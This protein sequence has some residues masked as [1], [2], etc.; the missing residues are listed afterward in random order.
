MSKIQVLAWRCDRD[1]CGHVWLAKEK[2]KACAKCK[3][4]NWDKEVGVKEREGSENEKT[5]K[6]KISKSQ[7]LNVGG[8]ASLDGSA[9]SP[10][11][12]RPEHPVNCPCMMCRP[13]K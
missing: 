6:N 9:V 4:R 1:G 2:P 13:K 10:I 3:A 11:Y 8:R 12:L 5:P 7:P